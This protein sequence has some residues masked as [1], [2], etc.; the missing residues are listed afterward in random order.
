MEDSRR[1]EGS[2]FAKG[3]SAFARE[4]YP[5]SG[6]ALRD[7]L[8]VLSLVRALP[9]AGYLRIRMS[10]GLSPSGMHWRCSI[11]SV[12]NMDVDLCIK[13][14]T[15][16]LV[17]GYSSSEE[18][19]PFGWKDAGGKSE[20]ELARMFVE[21][22]PEMAARGKGP[23][24]AYADWFAGIMVTAETGRVPVFYA[25]YEIDLSDVSVPPSPG[26]TRQTGAEDEPGIRD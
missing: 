10:S 2:W 4:R 17:A 16:S 7:I 3:K 6:P 22:F 8:R 19:A 11:T 12:D 25:D 15:C 18:D 9:E 24:P 13:E 23:D 1:P 21:R 26:D 5:A 20:S 14:S